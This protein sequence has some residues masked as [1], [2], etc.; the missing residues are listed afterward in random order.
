M[1]KTKAIV[2]LCIVVL[3]LAS[4]GTTAKAANQEP[5][6]ATETASAVTQQAANPAIPQTVI[7][8]YKNKA[9]GAPMPEWFMDAL[10]DDYDSFKEKFNCKDATIFKIEGKG[11]NLEL[12]QSWLQNAEFNYQ[13]A[14]SLQTIVEQRFSGVLSNKEK[15]QKAIYASSTK[16]KFA[17]FQKKTDFWAQ[18]RIIDNVKNTVKDEYNVVQFYTIDK[19]LYQKLLSSY[20]DTIIKDFDSADQKKAEAMADDLAKELSNTDLSSEVSR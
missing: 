9:F 2:L 4:C 7:I 5:A 17:G 10:Q 20:L 8:D 14:S 6:P 1:E 12:V 11:T 13:I 18:Q 15:T 19:E 3:I 16:A